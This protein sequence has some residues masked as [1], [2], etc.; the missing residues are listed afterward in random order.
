ME[1][2]TAIAIFAALSQDTRLRAFRLLV[3]AGPTGMPAGAISDALGTPHNT[4]SFH[5]N[6]LLHAGIVSS[7]KDGR[8]VIYSTNFEAMREL[9]AFMVKDCCGADVASIREDVAAGCSI[10]ELANCCPPQ[11]AP[12]TS[13]T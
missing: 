4:L 6:H 8:S 11:S 3:E 5:L 13:P 9:L 12:E 2:K 1:I 7:R 10:I